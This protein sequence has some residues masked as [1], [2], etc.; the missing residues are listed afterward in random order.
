[1]EF[2]YGGNSAESLL[3]W[4]LLFLSIVTNT[5][6][7]HGWYQIYDQVTILHNT[8]MIEVKCLFLWLVSPIHW[9]GPVWLDPKLGSIRPSSRVRYWW[10]IWRNLANCV[11][12]KGVLTRS[13]TLSFLWKLDS[14]HS[15]IH[16][17][18][19]WLCSSIFHWIVM[20]YELWDWGWGIKLL[21][22]S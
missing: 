21:H 10:C 17:R 18:S 8:I 13:R 7:I 20:V 19:H 4:P 12:E 2:S 9:T 5:W 3:L 22:A 11:D 1:M 16:P 15:A 14:L 6:L